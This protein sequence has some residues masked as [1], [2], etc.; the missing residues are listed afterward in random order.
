VVLIGENTADRIWIKYEIGA[1]WNTTKGLVGVYIHG[2]KDFEG[3]QSLKGRN[4][5]ADF[6][7]K[8]SGET[9]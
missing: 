1:A 3:N 5:F 9:P 2:L 7:M 6:T 8:S 4:P